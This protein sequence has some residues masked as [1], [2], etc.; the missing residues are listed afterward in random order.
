M[1]SPGSWQNAE[2]ALILENNDT[3]QQHKTAVC[4][5]CG[6]VKTLVVI[7]GPTASGKTALAIE[8]ATR[9]KAEIISAD[10]RQMFRGMPTG[11]AAP[12]ETELAA[13]PHHFI[14]TLEVTDYYSAA[15]F[16]EDVM[17][18]LPELFTRSDFAVMCGGSMMY[19]D[20]VTKGID[21]LPTI[22]DAIRQQAYGILENEGIEAVCA[23]LEELDPEYLA[24][25]DL[26]NHKRLVH[27]LEIC[28]ES[29]VPYS[30]LRTGTAKKR[31]FNIVKFAI[32]LPREI[33]FNRINQRVDR[34][35]ADGLLEEASALL[36]YRQ[37][38]ALNTVGYKEMFNYLD[39]IWDL[40]TATARI[41]KNTR[42]YAKKQLTWLKRDDSVI[43]LDGTLPVAEIAAQITGRLN[44]GSPDNITTNRKEK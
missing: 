30:S 24:T 6:P 32:G 16:E 3:R 1:K 10:S 36:P 2:H 22:S 13:V 17:G 28:I 18:L 39:G 37:Q 43:W 29:G 21:E 26:G 34:M 20:A 8:V 31:P 4:G 15:R 5:D 35:I 42:V 12:T 25:A 11:T 44:A 23:R 38:N 41:A 19:V 40:A 27:A 14:G 33:L 9:L 7:T